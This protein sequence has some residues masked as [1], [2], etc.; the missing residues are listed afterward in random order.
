MKLA[1]LS[2]L[3]VVAGVLGLVAL[4]AAS[5]YSY[6]RMQAKQAEIRD[7]LSLKQDVDDFSV[8]ADHMMLFHGGEALRQAVRAEGRRVQDRLE[9]LS[10]EHAGAQNGVRYVDLMLDTLASRGTT[11]PGSPATDTTG[12]GPMRLSLDQRAALGQMAN[13]G[14]GLDTALDG[15]L[16]AR[17]RTIAR[18]ATWIAGGFAA[19]AMLFAAF[20]VGGFAYLHR[21]IAGPVSGLTDAIRRVERGDTDARAPVNGRDE[22]AE[23]GAAFNRLRGQEETAAQ[24]ARAYQEELEARERLL[25]ESQRMARIG[26]WELDLTSHRLHWSDETYRIVGVSPEDFDHKPDSFYAR[27]HPN[28]LPALRES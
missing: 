15:V 1:H 4:A 27:V 26:S 13:H 19:V 17:Q 9:A 8:A 23:L 2:V 21:R 3:S 20:S 16:S 14:I 6:D 24:Q 5:A 22:L 18:E 28:D 10:A 7:L 25:A 11:G 12:Y